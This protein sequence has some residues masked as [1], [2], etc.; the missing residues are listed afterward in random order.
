[1]ESDLL[2]SKTKVQRAKYV[3]AD[4]V[5]VLVAWVLFFIFRRVEIETKFIQDIQLFSPIYNF[6]KLFFGIPIFWLFVF[7]LSGY[8]NKPFHKSRL[9]ELFLTLVSVFLGSLL[10]FF[11][12]ILDDP[13]VSYKHYYLSFVVLFLI[14][15]VVV[16]SF[17][18]V[19]TNVVVH[20]IH[21]GVWGFN[22]LVVGAGAT[23]R[24]IIEEM[25]S[26]K[27]MYGYKIV[28]C[29]CEKNVPVS[30][31]QELVLGSMSELET[32]IKQENIDAVI[33]ATDSDGHNSLF[34]VVNR[35]YEYN[36][37]ISF[38][39]KL[40]DY[41]VGGIRLSVIYGTPLVNILENRMPDW[42]QNVK[43]LFDIFV[44]VLGLIFLSPLFLYL[45]FMVKTTSSGGVFFR[46]ER[47]GLYGKPFN[48]IKFRTMYCNY[49]DSRRLTEQ[50]DERI[51]PIGKL[52]RKY[53]LDELPQLY[54]VLRGEMSIVG[55]RPE[56]RYFVEKILQKAPYY[57]LVHKVRP[58]LTSW[59][60]VKYGYANNVDKM[61]ERLKYDI[62]YLE[63][64]S[65]LIDFKIM[66]YTIKTIFSG[67]GI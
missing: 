43:R 24:G 63:N 57:S 67:E 25:E 30:V 38:K 12:L 66:V 59:G 53:R 10:L 50:N 44:S 17:R 46:Q 60:M 48:I 61:I 6:W 9:G 28:G 15:F 32:I 64:N 29:L 35:L 39:P 1:M 55:P 37:E 47:I 5:S 58:G 19:I 45:I 21:S 56:Q 11:I 33:I 41:L 36:V 34:S 20:K 65:L 51:T 52:M 49:S 40:Y 62:I 7:W 27:Q 31:S 3:A 18:V 14:Y 23:A 13:V 22:T 4:L 8:Y 26:G 2:K 42:Q 54:N 16:Y